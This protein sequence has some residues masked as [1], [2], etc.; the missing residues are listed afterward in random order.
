M[1]DASHMAERKTSTSNSAP[2]PA[3]FAEV[4]NSFRSMVKALRAADRDAVRE[5]GL[6]S[7]QIF[8][9]HG[10]AAR[11]VVSVNELADMTATDQ[12]TVSI[13]VSK[14]VARGLVESR[15]SETDARR[16][17]L[18]LTPEG[19]KLVRKLPVAFQ[20]SLFAALQQMPEERVDEIAAGLRE[21]ADLMGIREERPPMLLADV[22]DKTSRSRTSTKVAPRHKGR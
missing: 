8:V 10:I 16:A 18:A 19:R 13:V 1:I 17:E 7:A 5:Y 11:G 9:M 4:L 20:E 15:R 14:L 21:L 6:G 22:G 12:S 2:L 3:S